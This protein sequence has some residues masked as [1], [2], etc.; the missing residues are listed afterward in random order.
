MGFQGQLSSVQLADLFQTLHMN[1]QTGTLSVNDPQGLVHVYFDQGQ[2]ALC[3]APTI[4]GIP[5]LI[6]TVVRKG[7][8]APERA[9]EIAQ[10]LRQTNQPL[11]D[12]LLTSGLIAEPDLDEISAWCIEEL[13]CPLFELTDGDFTFILFGSCCASYSSASLSN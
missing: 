7:L 4:D 5:F 1:R 10:R 2:I 8:I 9:G 11:R 13:V 3:N 6:T 12:I